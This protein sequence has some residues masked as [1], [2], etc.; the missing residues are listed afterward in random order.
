MEDRRRLC[1][2]SA[3]ARHRRVSCRPPPA[4]GRAAFTDVARSGAAGGRGTMFR[5]RAALLDIDRRPLARPGLRSWRS[6]APSRPL[7]G[8]SRACEAG[9][10]LWCLP[11]SVIGFVLV[12]PGGGT[13]ERAG[14][15]AIWRSLAVPPL[16]ALALGWLAVARGRRRRCSCLPLFALAWLDRGGLAGE[17]RRLLLS[18]LS[19]VALGVLLASRHAAALARRGSSRWPSPTAPS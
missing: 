3:H 11:L 8:A 14:A 10:G 13:R 2:G 12:A 1:R 15:D 19:C 17:A 18:A 16:A 4:R 5:G 6:R 9:A 7:A